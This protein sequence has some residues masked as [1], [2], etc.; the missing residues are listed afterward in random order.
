MKSA[1]IGYTGFVGKNLEDQC[2]FT[3]IM[4]HK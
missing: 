2:D 1:L 3:H 4:F